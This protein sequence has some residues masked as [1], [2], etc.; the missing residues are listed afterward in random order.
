M[1]SFCWFKIL[2]WTLR[3][4][5]LLHTLQFW[6]IMFVIL[7]I[8][9]NSTRQKSDI[10]TRSKTDFREQ[11]RYENLHISNKLWKFDHQLYGRIKLRMPLYLSSRSYDAA[12]RVPERKSNLKLFYELFV[13]FFWH[14][15]I[16]HGF[17]SLKLSLHTAKW[18]N[19]V[20]VLQL[21]SFTCVV[22]ARV[23]ITDL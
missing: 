11:R 16:G 19:A 4:N 18:L 15:F 9:L 22:F 7:L 3:S 8:V 2:K 12:F 20:Q 13:D 23:T 14:I 5:A 17:E 21:L 1:V 10:S 6:H